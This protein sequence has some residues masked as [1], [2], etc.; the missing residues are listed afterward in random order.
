MHP[1][2]DHYVPAVDTVKSVIAP[3]GTPVYKN[4][5]GSTPTDHE[6]EDLASDIVHALVL[7]VDG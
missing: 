3:G 1:I 7:A 5:D 2:P 6:I 4:T